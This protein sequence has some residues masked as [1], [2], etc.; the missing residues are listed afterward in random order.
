[1]LCCNISIHASTREATGCSRCTDNPAIF[2]FTPLHERRHQ[3]TAKRPADHKISIHASTREATYRIPRI[4]S[5]S[6]ISIH[7]STRE[8]TSSLPYIRFPQCISIH[9]STREATATITQTI[10]ELTQFQFTPLPERRQTESRSSRLK[11]R[12]QFTP[13]HERRRCG[14][15]RST[16]PLLFQFTPL[17]ERRQKQIA[18]KP[19]LYGISIHASTREATRVAMRPNVSES[20]SIHASA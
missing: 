19:E 7:A 10:S 1:M 14:L 20:I 2:Q 6:L 16:H 9:A 17:H 18:F 12:F 5:M 15:C 3:T 11:R 13:L 8:A 4:P